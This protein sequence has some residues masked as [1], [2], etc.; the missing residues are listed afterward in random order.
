VG[1][2]DGGSGS[3][4]G[5]DQEDSTATAAATAGAARAAPT[6]APAAKPP[7]KPGKGRKCAD[8]ARVIHANPYIN[9]LPAGRPVT[10]RQVLR[11]NQEITTQTEAVRARAKTPEGK[12]ELDAE[13]ELAA[14]ACTSRSECPAG[15]LCADGKCVCPV[16]YSGD[17]N[18]TAHADVADWC[19]KPVTDMGF[20]EFA[21]S[22]MTTSAVSHISGSRGDLNTKAMFDTCAVVG[23]S[24]DLLKKKYGEEI[25]A[26]SAVI[27]FNDA[28]T[29]GKEAFVVGRCTLNQVDP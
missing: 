29:S 26:H 8:P 13:E 9:N 2:D 25:D 28:P 11:V 5:D 15:R 16:M 10:I 23:S 20:A 7:C 21:K 17:A 1:G 18:C 14:Q 19:I 3:S 24:G 12:A 27:R 4:G 22:R 6:P